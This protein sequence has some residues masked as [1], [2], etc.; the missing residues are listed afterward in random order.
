LDQ[1]LDFL[2]GG[3]RTSP[4][5]HR[6]LRATI[7]WS[8]DLLTPAQQRLFRRLSVFAGTFDLADA[9][10]VVAD[11]LLN[12]DEVEDLLEDLVEKS[13]LTVESG[14]FGIT[15]RL[16]ETIGQYAAERLREDE[17]TGMAERHAHWC[18]RRVTGIHQ[19]LT[20]PAEVE[21]VAV[22]GQLWPNLRAAFTWACA[23]GDHRLAAALVAP[24]AAELNLRR[25]SEIRAWAE[26]ILEIT[27]TD[28]EDQIGYWLTCATY[29]YK[30]NGDHAAYE[31]LAHRY[32]RKS[33][34][35]LVRYTRAYL[36]DDA[37]ALLVDAQQAVAWFRSHG[38][39]DAAMYAETAGVASA[40]LSTGRL[41]ELDHFVSVRVARYRAQ[42]PPTLLYV[43]LALLAY[44]ALFQGRANAA[45][46]LFDESGSIEVPP[47]TSSVNE[48]ARARKAFK[49]GQRS[50]AFRI[51]RSHVKE[52]LES[53]Y[54]DLGK[55][56][57]VEFV[58]MMSAINR[59]PEGAR[60][61]SYLAA[62][63][64]FGTLAVRGLVAD[65]AKK[66]K[67]DVSPGRSSLPQPDLDGRQALE[68]M[69]DVLGGLA[70][71]QPTDPGA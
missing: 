1:R 24:V 38:A 41:T 9:G 58:N 43:S 20:G 34:H 50:Q 8:Y 48:P 35:P 52:L 71:Q 4:E 47:K 37:E 57:A 32:A 29:G 64:D 42:G 22:L 27:P 54:T 5:R 17:S 63:G 31:R 61:L 30:Q 66:I 67:A 60:I 46:Q 69:Y 68:Y 2:T 56:A 39:V 6:T 21:G 40:L 3:R 33:D 14:P 49:N 26:R 11:R 65:A 36:Y 25:Q 18:L 12:R 10:S 55:L 45:E 51:L 53:D 15:F 62:T 19:L 13:M 7:Q 59:F 23:Q 44:S 28:D 70:E 16:A